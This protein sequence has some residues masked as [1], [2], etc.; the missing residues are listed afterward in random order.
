MIVTIL[1]MIIINAKIPNGCDWN[2][3][4]KLPVKMYDIEFPKPQPGQNSIPRFAKGQIV[5][6]V[7]PG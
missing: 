6:C 2:D 5:K 3:S 4:T 7:S 1:N